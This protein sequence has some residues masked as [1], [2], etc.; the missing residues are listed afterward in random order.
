MYEVIVFIGCEKNINIEIKFFECL[1]YHTV[2]LSCSQEKRWRHTAATV[3]S[4][5]AERLAVGTLV[6][7]R[8][9]LVGAHQNLIQRTVVFGITVIGTLLDGTFD[10]L[11]C[12]VVHDNFPPLIWV[13][14]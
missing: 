4:L 3:K 12:L 6:H 1:Y 11:V 10:A 2:F 7:G 14:T 5:F 9:L 13:R 8:I